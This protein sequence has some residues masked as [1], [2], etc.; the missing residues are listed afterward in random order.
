MATLLSTN[1]DLMTELSSK[2]CILIDIR[3][4]S[5]DDRIAIFGGRNFFEQLCF[6][7]TLYGDGTF[8]QVPKPFHHLYTFHGIYQ[9]EFVPLIYI[10][11]PDN[12]EQTYDRM[13][14]L[15]IEKLL[16]LQLYFVPK[17]L[18]LNF[19]KEIVRSAIKLYSDCEIKMLFNFKQMI[20]RKYNSMHL[21]NDN[22]S[23]TLNHL[24]EKIISSCDLVAWNDIIQC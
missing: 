15:I 22:D 5:Q 13:F 18:Y 11:L 7:Q 10:L 19:E 2:D 4:E 24:V 12:K 23:I 21:N 9:N 14:R 1:D 6:A 3:S 17:K 16:Q 20:L 8:Y